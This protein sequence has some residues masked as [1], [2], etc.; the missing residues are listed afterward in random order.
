L[1]EQ[2]QKIHKYQIAYRKIMEEMENA[3]LLTVYD[4]GFISMK[5][6]YLTI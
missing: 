3:R 2:I 4:A 5:K 6:Q 1:K